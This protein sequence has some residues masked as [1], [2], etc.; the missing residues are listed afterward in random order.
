M[1]INLAA[2]V[3]LLAALAWPGIASRA[4]AAAAD[5][6]AAEE[7]APLPGSRHS[8]RAKKPAADDGAAADDAEARP[9]RKAAPDGKGSVEDTLRERLALAQKNFHEQKVFGE[10]MAA[11]W[12]KFFTEL[13]ED[14][15]RFETSIA[16]QRL[17][18]FETMASVGPGFQSQAVGDFERMQSTMLRSFEASQKKKV[19]EYFGRMIEDL[20]AYGMEQ[21]RKSTE[22]VTA[23]MDAWKDQKE[24]LDAKPAKGKSK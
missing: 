3:G 24:M 1:K 18:L 11:G 10:K 17:N 6:A 4:D 9:R 22:L 7:E 12:E 15:K 13:F 14:R 23:A 5:D 2:L 19:D 8:R 20:K 21:T 16:R